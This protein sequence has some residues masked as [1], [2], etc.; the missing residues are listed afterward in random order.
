MSDRDGREGA[1]VEDERAVFDLAAL[2]AGAFGLLYFDD[3]GQIY[4]VCPAFF[5]SAG[6]ALGWLLFYQLPLLVEEQ[7]AQWGSGRRRY[8]RGAPSPG[9]LPATR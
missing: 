1:S 8:V 3:H 9:D 4:S 2:R 6:A 7:P 5:A